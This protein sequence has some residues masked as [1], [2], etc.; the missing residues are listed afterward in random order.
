[1]RVDGAEAAFARVREELTIAP[2]EPIASGETFVVEVT[3]H[4][5]PHPKLS[6]A[7]PFP[8]GWTNT[9][10]GQSYVA[11]EPD[12]AHTWFPAND[13]PLDKATFSFRI[14]V[15]RGVTAAANGSLVEQIPAAEGVTWIW[16]LSSPMAPYLA[17]VV[18]GEFDI[19]IDEASSEVAGIPI[20]NVLPAGSSSSDWPALGRQG[21]MILFLE[22]LFGPFPFA[23]YG[24]AIVD[25]FPTALENQTLSIFGPQ[26]VNEAILVHELAHQ[27]FGDS[28]SLGQWSDIW[29]NEGFASYAQWLW[30][31]RGDDE[32]TARALD[33]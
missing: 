6:P 7:L 22:G 14:T 27:W 16:E 21:E 23:T 10:S 18:I 32:P 1:M 12:A 25:E 2:A 33:R 15:P 28:V 30:T 29:L 5:A 19:V 20:R 8:V 3:Y 24:I 17:T 26:S 31:E 9:E 13:H 4:G 11:A